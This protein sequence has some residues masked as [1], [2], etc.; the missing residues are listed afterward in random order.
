MPLSS[1]CVIILTPHSLSDATWAEVRHC[2]D[3]KPERPPRGSSNCKTGGTDHL[4]ELVTFGCPTGSTKHASTSCSLYG[5]WCL[6]NENGAFMH[7]TIRVLATRDPHLCA[8]G[9]NPS[10]GRCWW[11]DGSPLHED[12]AQEGEEHTGPIE[13]PHPEPSVGLATAHITKIP[14]GLL[15][16]SLS[17]VPMRQYSG[18][19]VRTW[20]C[21]RQDHLPSYP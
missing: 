15:S 17:A 2:R 4:G 5:N 7:D 11:S 16:P 3:C 9:V 10:S 20:P 18:A 12:A 6:D 13:Y 8:C 19:G 1:M 14:L 21:S